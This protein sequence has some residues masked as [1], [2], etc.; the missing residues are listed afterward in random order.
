[1]AGRVAGSYSIALVP[2]AG[3]NHPRVA[4]KQGP[5]NLPGVRVAGAKVIT[6]VG[7]G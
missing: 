4:V 1:M 5:G 7:V 2:V 6:Y 3:F